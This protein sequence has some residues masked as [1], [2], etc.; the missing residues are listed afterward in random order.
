MKK[1]LITGTNGLLGQALVNELEKKY[2]ILPTGQEEKSPIPMNNDIYECFDITNFSQCKNLINEF[3]PDVI[4]NAASYTNVDDCE[5]NKEF[6]WQVNVKGVENLAQLA[7][8][9]DIH[10][11]HYSTDYVFDGKNGPYD[12]NEKPLPLGY[13]GKSKLA[14]E[15]VLR[16]IGCPFTIIR[17]CVLYG[18]GREVK[19][20]F[21]L[22][23]L[24][25]LRE[26]SPIKVVTDQ[27]NNPTLAEDLASGSMLV[28]DQAA[29]G[30]YHMAGNEYLNRFDFVK[31][32]ATVF[33]L[34]EKLISPVE[35]RELGQLAERPLYGGLKIEH[36]SDHL[37][38][39]PRSVNEALIYLKWKLRDNE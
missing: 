3:A 14:S 26:G 15:N 32:V 33:S 6:C 20:N 11:L 7:R 24:E 39:N 25:N 10:L 27:Y 31:N 22:W 13:Y 9:Y 34:N 29:V 17:T 30:L 28:I 36:A 5:R 21:F 38:Y 16:Q 18:T 1:V 35:T 4:V 19:K 2:Q 8:R 37:G 23:S 12:E